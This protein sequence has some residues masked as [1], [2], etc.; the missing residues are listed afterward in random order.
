MGGFLLI[1]FNHLK[2]NSYFFLK[3]S[4]MWELE[5]DKI[6]DSLFDF[7]DFDF[8]PDY[9]VST[10]KDNCLPTQTAALQTQPVIRKSSCAS[11]I[12]PLIARN[13]TI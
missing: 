9:S 8:Q 12:S 1:L 11:A 4:P 2:E 7:M 6:W 13:I 3:N 10:L 5:A